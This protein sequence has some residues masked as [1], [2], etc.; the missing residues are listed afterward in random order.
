MRLEEAATALG[1]SLDDITLDS[2][3]QT[4]KKL[5]VIWDPEKVF[6]VYV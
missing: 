5:T 4:F 2:L 3:K 1:I 6:M